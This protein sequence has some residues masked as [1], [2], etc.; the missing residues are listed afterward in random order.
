LVLKDA[1]LRDQLA[2]SGVLCFDME[3]AGALTDF[4]CLVIRGISNY[5]D[6][7]KN[8]TWQGFAAA[9]AAAYARQLFFHMPIDEVRQREP[10]G[11]AAYSPSSDSDFQRQ[12]FLDIPTLH[13]TTAA[14]ICRSKAPER[15][16]RSSFE[17]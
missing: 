9:V 7:H 2:S 4:P 11:Y 15:T 8:D 5:C 12:L 1:I 13:T 14:T 16:P 3:A 10:V 6:T 17:R